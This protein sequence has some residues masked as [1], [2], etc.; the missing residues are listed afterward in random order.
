MVLEGIEADEIDIDVGM[1]TA[2]VT[3]RVNRKIDASCG[4]GYLLL[5]LDN[6]E[7]D[8]NYE[9]ECS[10]GVIDVGDQT[11]G[12]LR[13]KAQ[14]DTGAYGECSLECSMGSIYGTCAK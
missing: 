4:M 2:T 13:K 11:Y 9:I 8:F 7:T 6:E 12:A 5:E 14:V 3:G 1:G 10:A